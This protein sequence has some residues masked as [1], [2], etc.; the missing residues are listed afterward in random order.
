MNVY[1]NFFSFPLADEKWYLIHKLLVYKIG[2]ER[3]VRNKLSKLLPK[4]A[5]TYIKYIYTNIFG[6]AVCQLAKANK[7]QQHDGQLFHTNLSVFL[8]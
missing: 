2:N 7:R 3:R 6:L 8:A 5:Y 4:C 1:N